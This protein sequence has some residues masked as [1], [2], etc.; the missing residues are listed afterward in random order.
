MP[1]EITTATK[2]RGWGR[3]F[4]RAVCILV[5][6]VAGA[7]GALKVW[8]WVTISRN[9]PRIGVSFDTAW[10]AQMGVTTKWYEVALT[11][12]G[13]RIVEVHYNDGS[14]EAFL[15]RIDALMLTGGGDIDPPVYGGEGGS[16]Q[17]VDRRRDDFELRLIRGALQRN[18]PI[19]GIC[20]GI[21]I[22]NVAQG[23]T[24]VDFRADEKRFATHGIDLSSMDA[25]AVDIRAGTRLAQLLG[26]GPRRA[27]S[28][29]GQ[30]VDRVGEGLRVAAVAPDGIIEA[31]ELPGYDF[32]IATQ[33]HPE[34][35]PH[36]MVVFEAFM[37]AAE[38]YGKRR[39]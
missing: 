3:F 39:N 17:L 16:A 36:Q 13:G 30:A 5:C 33:W 15:D 4:R 19:L 11:R 32:V 9:A 28:F 31:I 6:L 23:G 37:K 25:H 10:H 14:A 34:M 29:H 7:Y 8:Q 18:M 24:L 21:Q 26:V 22:L 2:R 12:A 27:N 38:A 35:P 20:R 1:S